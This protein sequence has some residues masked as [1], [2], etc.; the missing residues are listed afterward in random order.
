MKLLYNKVKEKT[1]T[2]TVTKE[3]K[4]TTLRT[5][6]RDKLKISPTWSNKINKKNEKCEDT[7]GTIIK[8]IKLV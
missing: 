3:D 8:N 4:I 2:V 7:Y 5:W 6:N 1:V